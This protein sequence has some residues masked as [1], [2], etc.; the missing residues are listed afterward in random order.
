MGYDTDAATGNQTQKRLEAMFPGVE[1]EIRTTDFLDAVE[2]GTAGSYDCVIANPPY[3]RAQ[4]M[5]SSRAQEIAKKLSLS[6]RVDI[7]YAF[8]LY[9]WG[10]PSSSIPQCCHALLFSLPGRHLTGIP[11]RLLLSIWKK[12]RIPPQKR[13]L[14]ST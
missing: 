7:Y 9:I 14:F 4:I 8:L 1:I 10:I 3:V 13:E 5:G 11:L 2:A 6:G 12:T